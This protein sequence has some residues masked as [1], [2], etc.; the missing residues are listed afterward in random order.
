[1]HPSQGSPHDKTQSSQ[2]PVIMP[3]LGTTGL[4]GGNSSAGTSTVLSL[5]V[6][7]CPSTPFQ[8]IKPSQIILVGE[9]YLLL[10]LFVEILIDTTLHSELLAPLLLTNIVALFTF[11]NITTESCKCFPELQAH[12]DESKMRKTE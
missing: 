10:L 5:V 12:G 1:M 2:V 4:R 11:K 7:L 8:F 6:S 3:F 9:L